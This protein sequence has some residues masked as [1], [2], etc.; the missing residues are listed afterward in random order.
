MRWGSLN[1]SQFPF[2]GVQKSLPQNAV[3]PHTVSGLICDKVQNRIDK[4]QN[5]IAETAR[6]G[7]VVTD[8][9]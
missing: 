1:E 4:V 9:N 6:S 3:M 7:G 5:R 2:H 8:L